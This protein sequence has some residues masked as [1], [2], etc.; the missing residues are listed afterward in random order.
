[1][2]APDLK[3]N[4][5]V[6]LYLLFSHNYIAFA[7]LTGLVIGILLS[8]YRPSRFATLIFLGFSVLLFSFEY[9]KH[10]IAAFREQTLISLITVN[11]HFRLQRLVN[12]FIS[13]LLP[14]I[15]YVT[16]WGILFAAI[17]SQGFKTGKERRLK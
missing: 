9:D 8:L 11:P 6:T 7:Y 15:F 5:F 14:V 12:L 16:G 17:V 13:E 1:M 2:I 10:L 4:I 3:Q